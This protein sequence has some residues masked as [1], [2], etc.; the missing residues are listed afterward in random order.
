[1]QPSIL[2]RDS[3]LS[4][5]FFTVSSL[6]FLIALIAALHVAAARSVCSADG[7]L[8]VELMRPRPVYLFYLW[9]S[10]WLSPI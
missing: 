7:A 2:V 3:S 6:F 1:M 9:P 4:L 5:L 8:G 10:S